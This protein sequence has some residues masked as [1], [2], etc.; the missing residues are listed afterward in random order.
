[1][2]VVICFSSNIKLILYT[3]SMTEKCKPKDI[4]NNILSMLLVI[5]KTRKCPSG[6]NSVMDK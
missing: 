5:Y 1:M 3:C 4:Y 2:S 6:I